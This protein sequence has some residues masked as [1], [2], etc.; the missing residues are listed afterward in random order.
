MSITVIIARLGAKEYVARVDKAQHVYLS[1]TFN[2]EGRSYAGLGKFVD[3]LER[4]NEYIGGDA[5]PFRQ[6]KIE[7]GR[8]IIQ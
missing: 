8:F 5:K 2:A 6:S 1:F 4:I 7:C 3:Y